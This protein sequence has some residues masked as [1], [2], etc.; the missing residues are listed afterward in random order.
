MNDRAEAIK[1]RVWAWQREDPKTRDSCGDSRR[2]HFGMALSAGV[3]TP[4][5]YE[6]MRDYYGN[7]WN[8]TGD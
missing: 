2:G 8:Y 3:I 7:L 6:T 4:E 5:E 1:Q